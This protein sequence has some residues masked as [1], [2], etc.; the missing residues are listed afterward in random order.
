MLEQRNLGHLP[1]IS[2]YDKLSNSSEQLSSQFPPLNFP[3]RRHSVPRVD[4]VL[5]PIHFSYFDFIQPSLSL[6]SLIGRMWHT[7]LELNSSKSKHIDQFCYRS[8]ILCWLLEESSKRRL[9]AKKTTNKRL[10]FLRDSL[11]TKIG[12][13]LL[14]PFETLRNF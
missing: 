7:L 9:T 13:N 8:I 11:R 4:A 2:N 5:Q 3:H 14:P 10:F 6:P 12:I 1:I